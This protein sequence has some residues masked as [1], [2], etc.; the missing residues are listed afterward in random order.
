VTAN[1]A[2]LLY[3]TIVAQTQS[4]AKQPDHNIK[5]LVVLTDGQDTAST[6]DLA[7]VIRAVQP[8]GADA[9]VNVKIFT[10][11]YG[12]DADPNVLTQIANA[13]GGQEYDGT[14]QNIRT[15]YSTISRFFS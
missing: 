2:T 10:I 12:S 1:G 13:S 5:A 3:D 8:S 11:A 7:G 6:V 15:I 9:G 14:P 4:L